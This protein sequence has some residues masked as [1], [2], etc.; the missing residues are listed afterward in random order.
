MKGLAP[1]T[2]IIPVSNGIF[3]H[4]ERI[5]AAIWA[6]L[7]LIDKTTKEVPAGGK[8]DG[9][10]LDGRSVAI[11]EIVSDLALSPR[12]VREHL[13]RLAEAGYIRKIDKGN[14]RPNG[15]AVVNSKRFAWTKK[16]AAMP[17]TPAEKRRGLPETPAEIRRGSEER[18]RQK[19]VMTP[20]EKRHDPGRNPPPY[21][22]TV[23]TVHTVHSLATV[24]SE[25]VAGELVLTEQDLKRTKKPAA[26]V[27]TVDPRYKACVELL[28][29]YWKSHGPK[30]PFPFGKPGGQQL[31][32]F[33]ENNPDLTT[34]QFAGL[35]RYRS[36]SQKN[37]A[38]PAHLWLG[39][40]MKYGGGPLNSY[41]QPLAG[42]SPPKRILRCVDDPPTPITHGARNGIARA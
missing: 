12:T 28:H 34:E 20:A 22:E 13:F 11:G 27:K 32:A 33:L 8:V 1:G 37:H 18:P 15:Y 17:E 38:K 6:F 10:V 5:G 42:F 36:L 30:M 23:H 24:L 9:L 2:Y 26:E 14:G 3:A 21:K 35:V 7:W 29:G 40:A 31:K 41:N 25:P 4:C 16:D 39:D 19:N